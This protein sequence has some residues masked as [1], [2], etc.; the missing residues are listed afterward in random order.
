MADVPT[1]SL[2]NHTRFDPPFHFFLLPLGLVAIVLSVIRIIHRPGIAS[3]LGVV[4][5]FGFVMI[6]FKARGY[7]LRVQDRVIR[8]EERLRLALLMPEAERARIGEL[9]EKQL[10]ALRFASDAELPGLAM[11]ALSEGLSGK[12]IKSSIVS[13][14][15]DYF[16]V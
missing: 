6:A 8:L 3:T 15:G 10:I 5:A 9:T 7:A 16:R 11:R 13:W 14:R 12:Q 4:L 2:A 1:Q